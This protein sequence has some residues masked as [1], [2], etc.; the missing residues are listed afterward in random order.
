MS[1][2]T[3]N[4]EKFIEYLKR[5]VSIALV[6]TVITLT[7]CGKEET[8]SEEIT[9]PTS[10]TTTTEQEF[11][12]STAEQST[13]ESITDEESTKTNEEKTTNPFKKIDVVV[14]DENFPIYSG[15]DEAGFKY[16]ITK[17][18][19]KLSSAYNYHIVDPKTE[20]IKTYHQTSQNSDI[21]TWFDL[22]SYDGELL[23]NNLSYTTFDI[24]PGTNFAVYKFEET[25]KYGILE[26]K[27]D[28]CERL[29][30]SAFTKVSIYQSEGKEQNQTQ[31]GF[32]II[33]ID[34][35]TEETRIYTQNLEIV[36]SGNM[37]AEEVH[38]AV[39][40]YQQTLQET[41]TT[42]HR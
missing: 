19:Q 13:T 40:A 25:D 12:T 23:L 9:S 28:H 1:K 15:T 8:T 29:I 33:G 14:K 21:K 38:E 36:T 24:I 18:N 30:H 7:A 39:T 42:T 10:I 2:I 35:D 17:E 4:K 37:T 3:F 41:T 34:E 16:L 31:N 32:Y 20:T 26:M 5:G 6:P 11:T 22:Y 27:E